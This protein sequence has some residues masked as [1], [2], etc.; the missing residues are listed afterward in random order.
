MDEGLLQ[1]AR[2]LRG[3][4]ADWYGCHNLMHA[5]AHPAFLNWLRGKSKCEPAVPACCAGACAFVQLAPCNLAHPCFLR[6][7]S[8]AAP[9]AAV[10]SCGTFG[11]THRCPGVWALCLHWPSGPH[12]CANA[13]PPARHCWRPG[14]RG[15]L[16]AVALPS[17]GAAAPPA[18]RPPVA[19]LRRGARGCS[20]ARVQSPVPGAPSGKAPQAGT[21]SVDS[22]VRAQSQRMRKRPQHPFAGGS[23][24]Q[25]APCHQ[26]RTLSC[27]AAFWQ[28]QA[29]APTRCPLARHP[30]LHRPQALPAT[31]Q[32]H[33]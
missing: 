13:P 32:H 9:V 2:L 26:A 16:A 20:P 28:S 8:S 3:G 33:E 17:S 10:Q 5:E 12:G 30:L 24:R 6:Q 23:G 11:R 29:H 22:T 1:S 18:M 15:L 14:S 19:V 25:A 7:P 31:M 27:S 21:P 4:S